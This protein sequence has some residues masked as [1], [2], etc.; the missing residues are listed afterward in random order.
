MAALQGRRC[1]P[2]VAG[3]S[4]VGE[5]PNAIT[6]PIGWVRGAQFSSSWYAVCTSLLTQSTCV[7][8]S[9]E[10]HNIHLWVGG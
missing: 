5:S 7:V 3:M 8:G 2:D 4:Q 6:Q 9:V 10:F 1:G